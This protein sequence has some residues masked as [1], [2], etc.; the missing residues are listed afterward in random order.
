M[1]N[2]IKLVA[3]AFF[4]LAIVL[5][6]TALADTVKS[7]TTDSTK[8]AAK[9]TV[10]DTG[11]KEQFGKSAK[12]EQLLDNAQNKANEKL[13]NLADKAKSGEDLPD[14]EKLFLKNL[15]GK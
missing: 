4:Y 5:P 13:N 3:I 11:V 10:K 6:Q 1:K 12:G 14:S 9:E 8:Q 15:Q 2:L 7:N